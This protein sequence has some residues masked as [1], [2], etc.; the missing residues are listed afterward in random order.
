VVKKTV[1]DIDVAGKRVLVRADFNVPLEDGKVADDTRIHAA[2]PTIQHL[3]GQRAR[4][5]LCAHLGRPKG[6]VVDELRLDPVA[7]RL[8][9]LLS[10]K[11][12]KL[13]DCVGSE[14]KRAV[15]DLAPGSVILLENTR[16]HAGEA[17]NDPDFARQLASLADVYVNDAFG[18]AHRAHAST[19]GVAHHVPAVA[20]L[21]MQ[22]ELATLGRVLGN[23]ERPFVALLGGAK[24]FDKIG[25]VG[26]L[27]ERADGLLIGGAMAST[28]LKASGINVGE[29]LV[30]A[31]SL[32]AARR[33]LEQGGDRVKIPSDVV[34][35]NAFEADADYRVIPVDEL[36]PET[37]IADI[38]PLTT[39]YFKAELESARTV[40]WN[41]PLGVFEAEPFAAGTF[42][43]AR[44]MAELD[45]TTVIGGGDTAAAVA[46]AGVADRM[47]HVS[48]GGG[49]FLTFLEGK[50]LPGVAALAER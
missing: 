50:E 24:V 11:V 33:I 47:T 34:I 45:A 1:K 28:F 2:L 35:T 14:T 23:P 36:F 31:E 20:G 13:G 21:L 46:R 42:D 30:E 22:R 32:D 6:K 43:I 10:R 38:G 16:F 9:E 3:L 19:E 27:L 12:T 8:S 41:G 4:V 5:I 7:D 44:A 18:A 48:T 15:D 26:Q 17:S 25:V 29:S 49:A 37:Q 40:V 39:E